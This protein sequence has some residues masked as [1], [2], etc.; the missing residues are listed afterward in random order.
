VFVRFGPEPRMRLYERGIRRRLAPMLG[1]DRA[2]IELAY[3]LQ[4]T[5]RGTPVLRY[6]E[7]IGMSDD[8]SLPDRQAIRTPM[9]WSGAPQAGFTT[10]DKPV[11][12]VVSD[13]RSVNVTDQRHDPTSLL[14]WF[15]RMIHTLRE[16]P[17][18]GSG[19]C[20]VIDVKLPP[21]VLA[22]RADG[23]SGSM[24]FLHNL[25]ETPSTVDL[26]MLCGESDHPNQV[27]GDQPDQPVGDLS[28]LE[29]GRYGYRWIR[30]NRSAA[31]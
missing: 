16:S 18:V 20:T 2:R 10:S 6:G 22:H 1:N 25:G 23:P 27:F 7:E 28:A 29:L 12:P 17:E 30:L 11:R 5:L 14:A 21:G 15:E 31:G 24:V 3:S 9:Q 13:Y 26:S 8:L 19:D 4:F